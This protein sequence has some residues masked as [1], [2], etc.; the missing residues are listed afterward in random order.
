MGLSEIRGVIIIYFREDIPGRML[1]RHNVPGDTEGLFVK[2][3]FYD[4]IISKSD[5]HKLVLYVF[6][7]TFPKSKPKEK[8]NKFYGF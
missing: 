6:K 7:T 1:T 4:F 2:S 8:T 3:K 5:F